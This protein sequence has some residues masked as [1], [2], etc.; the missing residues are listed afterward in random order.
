MF[1]SSILIR[2]C[3]YRFHPIARLVFRLSIGLAIA[4]AAFALLAEPNAIRFADS[5][6]VWRTVDA[7]KDTVPT[8]IA[9]GIFSAVWLDLGLRQ[10][11]QNGS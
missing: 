7:A 6:L 8:M 9:V 5:M 11:G 1:I 2:I 3:P 10:Y 4:L